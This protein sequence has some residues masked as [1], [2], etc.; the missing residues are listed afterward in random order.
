MERCKCSAGAL[1]FQ[2][3]VRIEAVNGLDEPHTADA[4]EIVE[5]GS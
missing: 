2:I 1:T 5:F 3:P 4:H